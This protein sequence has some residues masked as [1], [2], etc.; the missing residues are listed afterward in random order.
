M[1][2]S[3]PITCEEFK[4]H[5]FKG[6]IDASGVMDHAESCKSCGDIFKGIIAESVHKELEENT[7]TE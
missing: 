5:L 4:Q 7:N 1:E 3:A 6:D 2:K